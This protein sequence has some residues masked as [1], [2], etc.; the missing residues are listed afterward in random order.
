MGELI[1]VFETNS[2]ETVRGGEYYYII[3]TRKSGKAADQINVLQIG[4]LVRMEINS[5]VIY[6]DAFY[7]KNPYLK[8]KGCN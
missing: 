3:E 4:I 6:M 5:K 7:S 8:S 1:P 2:Y